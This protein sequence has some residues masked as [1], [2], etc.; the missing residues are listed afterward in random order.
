MKKLLFLFSLFLILPAHAQVMLA[1]TTGAIEM[2][3]STPY[4]ET[5]STT[6]TTSTDTSSIVAPV[7]QVKTDRE[8][9]TVPNIR[10]GLK[11]TKDVINFVSEQ[12]YQI[13]SNEEIVGTLGA[14]EAAKISYKNGRY[15]LQSESLDLESETF[16]RFEPIAADSVFNIPGC[17]I[18][19]TGRK[20]TYCAYRGTL[21]YRYSPKSKT[22]YLINELPLEDYMKGIAETDNNSAQGYIK[23]VL[24]AARSYA[25]KNISSVPAT[26]KRMFD[27]Y[28]TT[29][30]QLYLGYTS[31]QKMPRVAQFATEAAGEMVTYNNDVVTTPYFSRT[32]GATRDWKNS[33]GKNDRPWLISVQCKYDK[34]KKKAG[35]GHGMS[36]HDALMRATKDNWG[37]IQLLQYYYS[38]TQVEK[39]Y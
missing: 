19:Y 28:A 17:K 11:K 30:D 4:Q 10:V 6:F 31:E 20:I 35:H 26:E 25:Y 21:E 34:G 13:V 22:P 32:N 1:T 9:I 37:Y 38:N 18:S 8:L 7:Y 12:D 16:W 5:V 39:I 14:N 24:V 36:T 2:A 3:S 33:A 27:V 15:K 29:Q 23:A